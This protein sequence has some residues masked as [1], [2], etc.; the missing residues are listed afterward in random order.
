MPTSVETWYTHGTHMDN[1]WM[2]CVYWNQAAAVY[3]SLFFLSNF[4]TLNIFVT[5]FS[6]IVRPTKMKRG[7]HI[8]SGHMYRVYRNEGAAAYSSLYSF[9]SHIFLRN[10]EV[11]KVETWYTW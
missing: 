9:L 5:L 2:Y 1:G 11:Y 3:S 4:Q 7:T 8:D 10:C 6:G